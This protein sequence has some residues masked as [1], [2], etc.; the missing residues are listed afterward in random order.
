MD[1]IPFPIILHGG[2]NHTYIPLLYRCYRRNRN[3]PICVFQ[4]STKPQCSKFH[5]KG[6]KGKHVFSLTPLAWIRRW[7]APLRSRGLTFDTF[8]VIRH[9]TLLWMDTWHRKSTNY[10]TSTDCCHLS[11]NWTTMM[12]NNGTPWHDRDS[13]AHHCIHASTPTIMPQ[14]RDEVGASWCHWE[15]RR[16]VLMLSQSLPS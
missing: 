6:L 2:R 8:K 5:A 14:K 9:D 10:N 1:Q 4:V 16:R 11:N 12:L 15:S 3:F 13:L 7:I